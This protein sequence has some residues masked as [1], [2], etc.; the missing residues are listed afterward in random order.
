M[1]ALSQVLSTTGQLERRL[2]R[3]HAQPNGNDLLLH[4][5]LVHDVIADPTAL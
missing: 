2:A 1:M 4:R 3:L 5:G